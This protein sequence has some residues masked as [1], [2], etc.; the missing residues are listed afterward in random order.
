MKRILMKFRQFHIFGQS[1]EARYFHAS[2]NPY[3]TTE[4]Q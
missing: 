3:I 4:Q 1:R 2:G